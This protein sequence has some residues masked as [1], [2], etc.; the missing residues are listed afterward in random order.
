L[1]RKPSI[2]PA[3]NWSRHRDGLDAG[4]M[5]SPPRHDTQRLLFLSSVLEFWKMRKDTKDIAKI[6]QCEEWETY[7]AL[8]QALEIE[9]RRRIP[10]KL[11]RRLETLKNLGTIAKTGSPPDKQ[12]HD[13]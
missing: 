7:S 6:M 8:H 13:L 4:T 12:D 10:G 5:N 9:R 3:R 11:S 2:V 1:P